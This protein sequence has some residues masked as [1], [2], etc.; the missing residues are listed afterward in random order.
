MFIIESYLMF[1]S[2]PNKEYTCKLHSGIPRPQQKRKEYQT[3]FL[4]HVTESILVSLEDRGNGS[5]Q[6]SMISKPAV[7]WKLAW[8]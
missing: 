4:V 2:E 6:D 1:T 8:W 3:F 5:T 7:E